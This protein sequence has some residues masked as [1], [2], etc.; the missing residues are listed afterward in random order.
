VTAPGSSTKDRVKG[1]AIYSLLEWYLARP[2]ACSPK[3]LV[4][5]IQ[6]EHRALFRAD[7][8]ALGVSLLTWYPSPAIHALLERMMGG[9]PPAQRRELILGSARA[10]MGGTMNG[11][12]KAAFSLL[13]STPE[14]FRRTV[15]RVFSLYYEGGRVALNLDRPNGAE[16]VISEW[17]SH[18]PIGCEITAEGFNQ[19]FDGMGCEQARTVVTHCISRGDPLCRYQVTWADRR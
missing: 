2:D 15:V 17:G 9:R 18:H 19:V 4:D 10:V 13:T 16:V 12:F 6:P 3:E 11:P 8:K 7:R 1:L 14:M 5:A